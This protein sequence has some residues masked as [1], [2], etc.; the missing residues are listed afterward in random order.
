MKRILR[1]LRRGA[2]W[3]ALAGIAGTLG[4]QVE[5]PW[6]A[7]CFIA[8]ALCSVLALFAKKQK[9]KSLL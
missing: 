1:L 5:K 7:V 4:T 2:T 8:S 9:D 6:A 3:A